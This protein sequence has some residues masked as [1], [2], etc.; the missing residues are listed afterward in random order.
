ME[1]YFEET[2]RR[3]PS[4]ARLALLGYAPRHTLEDTL[5]RGIVHTSTPP[6]APAGPAPGPTAGG[7]KEAPAR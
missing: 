4:I 6:D 3:M 2:R 1:D 5:R 7:P